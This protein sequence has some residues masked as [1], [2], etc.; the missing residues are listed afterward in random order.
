MKKLIEKHKTTA[1]GLLTAAFL[2]GGVVRWMLDQ[3][4]AM[5]LGAYSGAIAGL[6]STLL[7]FLSKDGERPKKQEEVNL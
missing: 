3:I 4:D 5:E 1:V 7:G 2:I 6:A